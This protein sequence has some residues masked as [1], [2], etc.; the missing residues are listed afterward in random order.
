MACHPISDVRRLRTRRA[1]P[2]STRDRPVEWVGGRAVL[3]VFITEGQPYRPEAVVWLELPTE[4]VIGFTMLDPQR[5]Q[6]FADTLRE[7]MRAPQAGPPRRPA[8]VRVADEA[9]AAEVRAALGGASGKL[10]EV[11]VAPTPEVGEVVRLLAK[12]LPEGDEELSYLEGGRVSA[13]AVRALFTA[14]RDLYDAAPWEVA[15]DGQVLRLDIPELHAAGAALSIIGA[16]G[17]SLGFL[18]FPSLAAYDAFAEAGE[19]A[20]RGKRV[21]ANLDLGSDFLALNYYRGADLPAA[22]R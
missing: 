21:P 10:T 2:A 17:E 12:A 14:S 9:L 3:P 5:P 18:V 4:L 22:M 7:A 11:V 13:D 8:R 20:M 1:Q 16:L 15:N 6:P 19:R